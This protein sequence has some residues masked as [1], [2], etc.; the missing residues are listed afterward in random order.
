[1]S[2]R[3][4]DALLFG[5][6]A[7]YLADESR[8]LPVLV[9]GSLYPFESVLAAAAGAAGRA[10]R[11]R[12]LVEPRTEPRREALDLGPLDQVLQP[13]LQPVELATLDRTIRARRQ[14]V[15]HTTQLSK[16]ILDPATGSRAR[17]N[18]TMVDKVAAA[19]I[20]STVVISLG[21]S[22]GDRTSDV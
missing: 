7:W 13:S 9:L 1:M 15:D 22:F 18:L 10:R 12:E 20:V 11:R 17:T 16:R 21:A 19:V 8:Y 14:P 5:G 2:D 6:V 3:V 4:S